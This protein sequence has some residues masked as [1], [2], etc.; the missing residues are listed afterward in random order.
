[1]ETDSIN[2]AHRYTASLA[3]P[4][5]YQTP[6]VR[7]DCNAVEPDR[8]AVMMEKNKNIHADDVLTAKENKNLYVSSMG[9]MTEKKS[10]NA[11]VDNMPPY[12]YPPIDL[13][14]RGEVEDPSVRINRDMKNAHLLEETLLSFK[15]NAKLTGIAHGPAI[16]RFEL[17]I[18]P[19][20]RFN[21]ISAIEKEIAMS[22]A[23]S[24]I[25]LELPIPGKAAIGIGIPNERVEK[26]NLRRILE[27]YE[28]RKHPSKIAVGLGKDNSGRYIV[29]DIAK[30][31]HVLIAGQTGSGKSVC[32]DSIIISILFRA[33][34]EEV[35][36]ILIDTKKVDLSIYNGIPHLF[37]PVIYDSSKA[38]GA[39]DWAS[40]EMSSRYNL[41]AEEGVRDLKGYNK[42]SKPGKKQMP[43]VL[44]IIDEIADI[45]REKQGECE[46]I[47]CRLSQFG[48]NSGIHLVIA[49]QRPS[50]N[51]IT[52]SIKT[53]IPTRIAFAVPSQIDSRT[54]I[55]H[56]GAEKLLG[57][58]DMLFV[59][60]GMKSMRVQGAWVS[61][62]EIHA[63]VE[64][65]KQSNE[66]NY[67]K[68]MLEH[69]ENAMRTDTEKEE[70]A[71][72]YDPRLPEA[73]DIVIDMGQASIS[74]LQR[75]MRI[76][77]A[78]AGRLIDEMVQRGIV[79]EAD[80]AKPHQVLITSEEAQAM[81][82]DI[83]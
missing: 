6:S 72:E 33:S 77:Y 7:F 46:D 47:I 32:I 57:N 51:V 18:G 70:V 63:V 23:A 60:N 55:D 53:N 36:M 43:Q 75:R 54:I 22:V 19:G 68:N 49:T 2:H 78:K 31:P 81:F 29:A 4:E 17:E 28:A 44:I 15:I 26:I 11:H 69:M 65:I 45:M 12:I 16:T 76:G 82:E 73:I 83:K 30:M 40:A 8:S 67:D 24:S 13:L 62:E 25:D 52:G 48:A 59:P 34:P 27:S 21:R 61:D 50:V 14:T 5:V 10:C 42:V 9:L 79:S 37:C 71:S 3:K 74:M 35:R 38:I 66:A 80:G 64:Y 58:G 39:L 20:I 41:F 1:M 56:G